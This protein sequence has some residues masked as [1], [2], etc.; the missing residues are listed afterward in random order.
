MVAV[1]RGWAEARL[2]LLLTGEPVD[3]RG[4]RFGLVNR[5]VPDD[6]L[7]RHRGDR[8]ADRRQVPLTVAIG[9]EAYRRQRDLTLVDAYGCARR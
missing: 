4:P 5:V 2:E 6:E 7:R 1:A 8:R 9:K 3:R